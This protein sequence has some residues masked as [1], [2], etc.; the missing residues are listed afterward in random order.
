MSVIDPGTWS[1]LAPRPNEAGTGL[2]MMRLP[3]GGH[4][5]ADDLLDAVVGE[6]QH[7]FSLLTGDRVLDHND[8]V[9]RHPQRLRPLLRCGDEPLGNDGRCRPASLL[10]GYAVV[11]TPRC[12]RPSIRHPVDEGIACRRQLVQHSV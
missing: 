7:V 10:Y 2:G 3:Y 9:R 11:E 8:R 6:L 4:Q 5:S 12:A 1:R